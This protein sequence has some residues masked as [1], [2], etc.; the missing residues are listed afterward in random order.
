MTDR[1]PIQFCAECA[2]R[3]IPTWRGWPL[4]NEIPVLPVI[5]D[6]RCTTCGSDEV[7]LSTCVMWKNVHGEGSTGLPTYWGLEVVPDEAPGADRWL[8]KWGLPYCR[9]IVCRWCRGQAIESLHL[10]ETRLQ[11]SCSGFIGKRVA[12]DQG[13]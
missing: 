2:R 13:D 3:L 5:M 12:V 6:E 8:E 1:N 7:L 4:D 9:Q 11:C 10:T